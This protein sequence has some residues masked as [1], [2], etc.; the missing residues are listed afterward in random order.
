MEKK[1]KKKLEMKPTKLSILW[2]IFLVY[3]FLDEAKQKWKNTENSF[4]CHFFFGK[5]L[6]L[7][8]HI[9]S[10]YAHQYSDE[11]AHT[12]EHKHVHLACDCTAHHRTCNGGQIFSFSFFVLCT[13]V[14]FKSTAFSTLLSNQIIFFFWSFVS[15]FLLLLGIAVFLLILF[16]LLR[17]KNFTQQLTFTESLPWNM[18]K[19]FFFT[20]NEGHFT[21]YFFCISWIENDPLLF[22]VFFSSF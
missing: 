5:T 9:C 14:R 17:W 2:E 6:D 16:Y 1:P 8:A 20:I 21:N 10:S 3:R 12:H 4:L 15:S 19:Y 22:H 18:K 13:P 11:C 7:H